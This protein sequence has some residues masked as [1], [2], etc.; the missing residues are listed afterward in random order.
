VRSHRYDVTSQ[1]LRIRRGVLSRLTQELELY[2]V[3]DLTLA[4]PFL[5]RL[6]GLSS[7]HLHTSDRSNPLVV[8]R[9]VRNGDGLREQLRSCVEVQRKV[10]GVREL[11][12]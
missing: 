7:I 5:Y 8:I 3:K 11:D 10:H 1:R 12:V 2:R 9:A 6:I 4:E